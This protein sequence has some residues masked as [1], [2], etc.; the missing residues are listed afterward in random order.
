MRPRAQEGDVDRQRAL[1][2][3]VMRIY[4]DDVIHVPLHQQWIAW[5]LRDGID[6][7]QPADNM[8]RPHWITVR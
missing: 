4:H 6:A 1:I 5:G 2:G 7:V 8:M 3:E